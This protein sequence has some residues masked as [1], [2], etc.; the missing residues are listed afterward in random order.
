M[1]LYVLG[2]ALVFAFGCGVAC[3][4]GCPFSYQGVLGESLFV[5]IKEVVHWVL[6]ASFLFLFVI[7]SVVFW[8]NLLLLWELGVLTEQGIW[9]A[10]GEAV[11]RKRDIYI[12]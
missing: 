5:K 8:G 6:A 4:W 2:F 1:A 7:S 3:F 9:A 10:T 11:A 12:I